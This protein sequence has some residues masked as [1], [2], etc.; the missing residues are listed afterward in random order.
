MWQ[1]HEVKF[2][3]SFTLLAQ[4]TYATTA[5]MVC[6]L[7]VRMRTLSSKTS[8]NFPTLG[9]RHPLSERQYLSLASR[10]SS[11]IYIARLAIEGRI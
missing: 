5:L 6:V 9:F 11:Q 7:N 3:Y 4:C 1:T 8:D 2:S 10:V